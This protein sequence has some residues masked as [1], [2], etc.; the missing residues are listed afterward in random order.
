MRRNKNCGYCSGP[1]QSLDPAGLAIK[2]ALER[3][4]KN[5]VND[6]AEKRP[7]YMEQTARRNLP[8][9]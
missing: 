2:E 8:T 1:N 4:I 7:K 5:S 3:E 9:S 6:V